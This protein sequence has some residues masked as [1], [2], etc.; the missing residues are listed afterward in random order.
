MVNYSPCMVRNVAQMD[1]P[2][3][4]GRPAADHA[5]TWVQT[6]RSTH[7]AWA[8]LIGK[9]PKAAVLLHLLVGRV[10]DQNAVVVSQKTLAK[11]MET[12]VSTV[13]RAISVLKKGNWIQAVRLNG[14]GTVAAYILNDQVA[15]TQPRGKLSLSMFSAA[16]V[17]DLED[18]TPEDLEKKKLR[19]IPVL[20]PNEQQ[21]PSGPSDDPPSQGLLPGLEPDLPTT[22]P[23]QHQLFLDD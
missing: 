5:R 17:A 3:T 13:K 4:I 10:G 22:D 16:I 6:Q 23:H 20:Y 21:L 18:Q 2:Q 15:W 12:H 14:T 1:P 19:R 7:E 8:H 11:M 9:E